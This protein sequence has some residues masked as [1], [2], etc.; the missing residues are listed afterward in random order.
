MEKRNHIQKLSYVVKAS[1]LGISLDVVQVD[2]MMH[3]GEVFKNPT[4]FYKGCVQEAKYFYEG[5]V[6]NNILDLD[7][8]HI[9]RMANKFAIQN[10][11]KLFHTLNIYEELYDVDSLMGKYNAVVKEIVMFNGYLRLWAIV[12]DNNSFVICFDAGNGWYK[13][14]SELSTN[15]NIKLLKG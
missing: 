7:E 9:S 10:S 1:G 5:L 3:Y 15:G 12:F 11:W 2:A 6:A 4:N 8:N 13:I 14:M